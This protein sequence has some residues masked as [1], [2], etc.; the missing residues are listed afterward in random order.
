MT[1]E[2]CNM[3]WRETGHAIY[4]DRCPIVDQQ[5]ADADVSAATSTAQT[6]NVNQSGNYF[7]DT[8]QHLVLAFLNQ[9]KGS[10]S[11]DRIQK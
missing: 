9:Y 11:V 6:R 3:E 10:E 8:I 5:L 4:G 1:I 7:I 2:T